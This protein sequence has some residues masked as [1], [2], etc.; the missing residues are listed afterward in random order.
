VQRTFALAPMRRCTAPAASLIS[1]RRD[2]RPHPGA[3]SRYV[4]VLLIGATRQSVMRRLTKAND[5]YRRTK[6]FTEK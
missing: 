2:E 4:A 5:K 6:W 1:V 3:F